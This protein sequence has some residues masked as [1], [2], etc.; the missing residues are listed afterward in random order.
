MDTERDAP[1]HAEP[2]Y[3]IPDG[4]KVVLHARATSL[5]VPAAVAGAIVQGLLPLLDGERSAAQVVEAAT[6]AM[7]REHAG[8]LLALLTRHGLAVAGERPPPLGETLRRRIEPVRRYFARDAHGGWGAVAALRQACVAV[9]NLGTTAPA[10]LSN[11][12]HAGVGRL[13]FVTPDEVSARD[14]SGAALLHGGDAGRSWR[15]VLAQ[16][17]PAA[18]FETRLEVVAPP[19]DAAGWRAALGDADAAV[20]A[21]DGPSYAH[22]ALAQLN[23]AA[24]E[25]GLRWTLAAN[26]QRAGNMTVGP[27]VIPGSTACHACFLQQVR[28]GQGGDR[29]PDLIEAYLREGGPRVELGSFAPL[30]EL[31]ANVATLEVCDLLVSGRA[32]RSAGHLLVI[33]TETYGLSLRPVPRL[34]RCP[35]CARAHAAPT[36]TWS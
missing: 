17:F 2:F 34:A 11:L 24:L 29:L 26:V 27:T 15:E 25:I 28:D 3:L 20:V 9:V 8:A 35:A 4:D 21:L 32:C 5:R 33:D 23:A 14:L 30:A 19:A 22:P 12:A 16:R 13:L 7:P 1:L 6:A 36:P 18:K 31:A 10:L